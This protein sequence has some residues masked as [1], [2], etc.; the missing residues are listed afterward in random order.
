[1]AFNEGMKIFILIGL[2]QKPF[3][4]M[5]NLPP[6][7]NLNIIIFIANSNSI[8][9]MK[10]YMLLVAVLMTTVSFAQTRLLTEQDYSQKPHWIKMIEIEGVNF[11]E[12][13][14][15]YDIYWQHHKMPGEDGDRYIGKGDQ[16]KKKLSKKELKESREEAE[17]QFQIKKFLH[18]KI[19]YE[20]FV[21]ENGNIMTAAERLAFHKQYN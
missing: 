8:S 21:K 16:K 18:W 4:Y 12:T 10:K 14:K 17:M 2:V 5:L 6:E 15:A 3:F 20:P 7:I 9:M 13:V 19:K 1:M 11:N